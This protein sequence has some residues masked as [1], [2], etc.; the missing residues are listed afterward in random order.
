M[1]SGSGVAS[2]GWSVRVGA[3]FTGLSHKSSWSNGEKLVTIHSVGS[4]TM[5][6]LRGLISESESLLYP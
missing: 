2:L 6:L 3:V 1:S 4:P 5:L